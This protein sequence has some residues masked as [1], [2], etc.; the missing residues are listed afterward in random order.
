MNFKTIIC[1]ILTVS[2][3]FGMMS[4]NSKVEEKSETAKVEDVKKERIV[5]VFNYDNEQE[6]S[7][8]NALNLDDTHPNLLNPQIS[9]SDYDKVVTSWTDLHQQIGNYIAENE[10]SWEVSDSSITIVHKIYFNPN[11]EIQ[12]YFFKVMNESV[13]QDKRE[14][15]ADLI[16]SF[17]KNHRIDFKKDEDFAQCGK[18]RYL[19]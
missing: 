13:N 12:N 6:L 7:E 2:M 1:T 3:F 8:F 9:K 18:T 19:N 17:A 5:S 16:S 10:F 15:F 11:G 14:Q 4:C